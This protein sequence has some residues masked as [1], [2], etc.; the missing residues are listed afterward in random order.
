MKSI[1]ADNHEI[2]VNQ[3]FT[4]GLQQEAVKHG[5]KIPYKNLSEGVCLGLTLQWLCSDNFHQFEE[6][7]STPESK[8]FIRSIMHMQ[9]LQTTMKFRKLNSLS[10]SIFGC[11]HNFMYAEVRKGWQ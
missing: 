5:I 8:A 7:R 1:I 6:I 4:A 11:P 3:L 9:S 10:T 2:Y